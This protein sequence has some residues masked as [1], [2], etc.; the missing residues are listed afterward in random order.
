MVYGI[1]YLI[2]QIIEWAIIAFIAAFAVQFATN[3]AVKFKPSYG[4][5]YKA[6]FLSFAAPLVVS[7]V[8]GYVIG[9]SGIQMSV[10]TLMLV[11]IVIGFFL[12]AYLYGILLKHPNKEVIGFSK[13]LQVTLIQLLILSII[14]G[15]TSA[16]V[17]IVAIVS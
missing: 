12:Q 16:I 4:M 13:G 7:F 3:F 14:A 1:S 9:T 17:R 8:I 15:V 11:V 2:G 5:A 10:A 6:A